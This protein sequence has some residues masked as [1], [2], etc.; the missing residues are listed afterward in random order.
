MEKTRHNDQ[1]L[2]RR[3]KHQTKSHSLEDIIKEYCLKRNSFN[4][5]QP[6]PNFFIDKLEVRM[7]RYYNNLYKS[8][9]R[10]TE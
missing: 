1:R 8:E 4:P 6:S 9:I 5:E 3:K 7:K 2:S 10:F